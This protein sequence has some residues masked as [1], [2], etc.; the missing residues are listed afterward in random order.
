MFLLFEISQIHFFFFE[1]GIVLKKRTFRIVVESLMS[2][3][4]K[5]FK[6]SGIKFFNFPVQPLNSTLTKK[7][8]IV[9]NHIK[10]ERG[11]ICLNSFYDHL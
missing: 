11:E 10:L 6:V 2:I 9:G 5:R 3:L 8:S 7:N 1:R 4:N